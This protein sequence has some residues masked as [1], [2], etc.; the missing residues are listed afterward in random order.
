MKSINQHIHRTS[1]AHIF[2][3]LVYYVKTSIFS[4]IKCFDVQNNVV[5][6]GVHSNDDWLLWPEPPQ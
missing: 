3:L 1:K 4:Q 2:N 5:V 6:G